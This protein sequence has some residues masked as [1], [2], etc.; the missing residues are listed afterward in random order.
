MAVKTSVGLTD[1]VN[2][3]R[4][5]TQGGVFGSLMCSNSIDTLGM[6]CFNYGENLFL[7]KK[8]VLILLESNNAIVNG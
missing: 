6:K 8:M 1:R 4:I 2:V 7:Y 5:V 3:S